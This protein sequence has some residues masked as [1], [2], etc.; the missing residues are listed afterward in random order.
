MTH[1]L[2]L[3][4]WVLHMSTLDLATRFNSC[5]SL[6]SLPKLA[7]LAIGVDRASAGAMLAR[8][9]LPDDLRVVL[10]RYIGSVVPLSTGV[11]VS[12]ILRR[13]SHFL[14]DLAARV[15]LR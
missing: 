1:S 12:V 11:N 10:T 2:S 7:A 13:S 9:A 8:P 5:L 14:T 6:A 15:L 3:L 4:G